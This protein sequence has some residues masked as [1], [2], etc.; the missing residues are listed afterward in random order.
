MVK[1]NRQKFGYWGEG[2]AGEYLIK[3]GYIILDRNVRTPYGEID[4]IAQ[5]A[6][7]KSS[8][9]LIFVEVK[10]RKTNTYGFPEDAITAQKREHMISSA[11]FYLQ[12]HAN[13]SGD[14]RIDVISIRKVKESKSLEIIHFENAV[15]E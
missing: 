2:V 15:S 14:W 1:T 8:G 10:T 3:K 5:E 7:V 13:F 12:E 11:E 4:L 9:L 6:N